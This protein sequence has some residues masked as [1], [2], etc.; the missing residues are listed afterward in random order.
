[1]PRNET[2][3]QNAI[4]EAIEY[5]FTESQYGP[6][7]SRSDIRIC[8]PASGAQAKEVEAFGR[9]PFDVG[10]FAL[11]TTALFF[12]IKERNTS[13]RVAEFKD[14]QL[15]MLKTLA[16]NGVDIRY[17]YNTWDFS[18]S[19]RL[20][21]NEVLERAHVRE[22]KHMKEKI[23]ILPIAPAQT[24]LDYLNQTGSGGGKKLVDVLSK[25]FRNIDNFNS[26]PLMILTN[27]DAQHSKVLIDRAPAGALKMMKLFFDLSD[28]NRSDIRAKLALKK[29]TVPLIPVA[30]A[31]FSLKD[32]WTSSNKSTMG[33]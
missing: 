13:G 14:K 28:N 22:A 27:L 11:N 17:A 10:F 12:E 9:K 6:M 4:I 19:V 33:P 32:S 23:D 29:K 8:T 24:L 26:M 21:E 30:D 25:S 7:I 1:M 5:Y 20:P 18:W 31:I 2:E 16:Q 15:S 3:I